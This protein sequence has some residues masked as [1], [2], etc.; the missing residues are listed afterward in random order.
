MII[1]YLLDVR[2]NKY[3]HSADTPP[4]IGSIQEARRRLIEG[5][6]NLP[7]PSQA[8]TTWDK[9]QFLV[10]CNYGDEAL[11][12]RELIYACIAN[13]YGLLDNTWLTRFRETNRQYRVLQAL[14]YEI[15]YN[16]K[17]VQYY[18]SKN[19]E[20]FLE[21]D[22]RMQ[23]QLRTTIAAAIQQKSEDFLMGHVPMFLP[24][25][26]DA[27]SEFNKKLKKEVVSYKEL[28][29]GEISSRLHVISSFVDNLMWD[30]P[31]WAYDKNYIYDHSSL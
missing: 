21:F 29:M 14:I 3:T 24:F 23:R 31:T 6:I 26:W 4:T 27:V 10:K 18:T 13:F 7:E 15:D 5:E 17:V 20:G 9:D 1:G 22:R 8:M 11:F 16:V 12:L 28:D 19:L 2:R 25:Y 30:Y